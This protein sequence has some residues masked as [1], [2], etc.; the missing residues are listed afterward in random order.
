MLTPEHFGVIAVFF[1]IADGL[2]QFTETGFKKALTQRAT[3]ENRVLNTAW[4]IAVIRGI[5]LFLFVYLASPLLL[6]ILNAPSS[7]TVVRILG[8]TLLLTGFNNVGVIH[9]K[10]RLEF[11]KEF[12]WKSWGLVAN[13]STSIP[14]AFVLKNEWAI[15][16]GL[17]ASK[18]VELLLSYV[19]HPYRPTFEFDRKSFRELFGYGKWLFLSAIIMF[20]SKQGDRIVVSNMLGQVELGIYSIAL[21][22]ASLPELLSNQVMSALFPAYAKFQNNTEKLKNV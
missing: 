6:D 15:V 5:I 14:L 12:W 7:L 8:L 13:V 17:L 21:R 20:F 10:R 19:L 3:V 18:T 1:I 9:F 4:S 11:Q 16:W 2:T 22:F